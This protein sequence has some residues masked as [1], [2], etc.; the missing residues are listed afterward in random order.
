MSKTPESDEQKKVI[1]WVRH[2]EESIPALR[3]IYHPAGS[4]F[5]MG[6]GV[7]RWLQLLGVRKGVWDLHL[8][9]D[10][11]TWSSLWIEMKGP[12]GKLTKEQIAF[13]KNI[14]DT[15]LKTPQMVVC[16]TAED[17]IRVIKDYL[18]MLDEE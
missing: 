2:H 12:K 13:S 8:P 5:G 7:I 14:C 11:G 18:K 16:T 3:T 15:S 10:N 6:F 9:L 4:Y 1:A 17:A